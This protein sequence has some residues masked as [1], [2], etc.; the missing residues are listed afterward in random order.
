MK[1]LSITALLL[2]SI[3]V[4]GTACSGNQPAASGTAT[5]APVA[6]APA[7]PAEG[8]ST[9]GETA[10]VDADNPW[11]SFDTSKEEHLIFYAVGT[12]GSDHEKVVELASNRMKELINTTFEVEIIPL[13][14]FQTKYP[15]VLAGGEDVDIIMTH[16]YIGPFTTHAD[17][18]AFY[19]LTDEFLNT[20]MPETMKSQIPV[21][22]DQAMYRNKLYQIPRNDSDY[23]NSYGVVVRKD[24]RD[25]YGIGEI[26]SI[27]DMQEYLYAVADGEKDSGMFAM[28]VNPT[29]PLTITFLTG[30]NN[31]FSIGGMY[32]DADNE[33]TITPDQIFNFVETP[34]YRE[35][36]LRM[37]E[38]AKHGVWPSNAITNVTHLTDL[39][40]EEKSASDITMYKAGNQDILDMREKGI[41]AEYFN[42]LPETANTRISP[43]NY[44]ALAITSFSKNPERAALAVDVMKNDVEIGNLLQGGIE[45]EHYI[46]NA[47]DNTHANGPAAEAYPWSGWAWCL[48][49]AFNPEE[50]GIEPKVAAIREQYDAVNLDPARFPVDGFT[51]DNTEFEAETA[52]LNSLNQEWATSFDLGV[53]GDDTEAK[54]DEYIALMKE[55]GVDLVLSENQ[56]QFAEFLASK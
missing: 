22:W 11:S 3:L 2:A 18:G 49:S 15:L 31:W 39:F 8:E 42:I 37:A 54:L 53:F 45:G 35:Y 50:G 16:P 12:K 29:V 56:R 26:T 46:Y 24:M 19:E 52:L 13:S 9:D 38:W 32:W 27:D 33:G 20:W 48:R 1:K 47:A 36:C 4:I 41:E 23:E 17:N 40:S 25:K 7:E 10:A 55:A 14:D 30:I 51:V 43:Y 34:E 6:E 44:D 28:Y 5:D 21:S